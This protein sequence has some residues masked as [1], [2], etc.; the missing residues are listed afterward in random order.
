MCDCGY[1]LAGV[2]F[3]G[4]VVSFEISVGA[5]YVWSDSGM[6]LTMY[7][8]YG[9]KSTWAPR[10][11]LLI[12]TIFF[13]RMFAILMKESNMGLLFSIFLNIFT[14]I[15]VDSDSRTT[16]SLYIFN[17]NLWFMHMA[18]SLQH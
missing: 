3:A 11:V 6:A 12:R 14:C 2:G 13:S 17:S 5:G 4:L 15:G 9:T 18:T 7:V 1:R 8:Q 10:A 16:G